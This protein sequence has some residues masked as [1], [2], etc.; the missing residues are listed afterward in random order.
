MLL[1][2]LAQTTQCFDLNLP[3]SLAREADLFERTHLVAA[4]TKPPADHLTLLLG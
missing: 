4:Q 2:R 3:H 1:H